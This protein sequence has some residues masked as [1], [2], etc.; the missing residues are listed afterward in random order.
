MKNVLWFIGGGL[1]GI[2]TAIAFMIF[3]LALYDHNGLL[4]RYEQP[5]YSARCILIPK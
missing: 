1:L 4:V 5:Q 3:I 2:A